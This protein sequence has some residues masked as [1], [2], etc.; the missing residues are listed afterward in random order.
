MKASPLLSIDNLSINFQVHGGIVKA[1]R[2]VS[3][4]IFPG[5]TLAVVGESGSGKSVTMQAILDLLP[6]PPAKVVAGSIEFQG[7]NLLNMSGKE[8]RRIA[9]KDIAMIFQ[10]PMA[11]LNPTMTIGRQI[12]EVLKLHTSLSKSERIARVEDMLALVKIPEAKKRMKQYPHELSGGMR[13]RVMIAMAL[14]TKPKVLIA[15]EPTTALDVTIQAQILLLMQE[16][17]KSLGM[18]TIIVTHDLGVV[19]RIADRMAVMYAGE[20]VEEGLVTDVLT[21]PSHPYTLGLKRAIPDEAVERLT[22]IE[23]TPPDLFFSPVGCAYASR[24]PSAMHVCTKLTPPAASGDNRQ[25]HCWLHHPDAR[26][27]IEISGVK[28]LTEVTP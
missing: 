18:A 6:T 7:K 21:A 27:Q 13:Q 2:S 14:A 4:Q 28:P 15:D 9:G 22:A 3:L 12:D 1:V 23:G 10:D 20:I 11:S 5:E 25:V 19:A 26:S 8:R 24:C 17:S 16:L